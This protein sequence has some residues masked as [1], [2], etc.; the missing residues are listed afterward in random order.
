MVIKSCSAIFDRS[1][2][3]PMKMNKGT[4]TS[5]SLTMTPR[6]RDAR[7]PRLLGSNTPSQ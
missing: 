1:S 4:A 3:T 5:T 2:I 6:Y 7:L